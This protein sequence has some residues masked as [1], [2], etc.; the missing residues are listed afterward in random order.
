MKL[1]ITGA[2]GR[3]ASCFIDTYGAGYD[4]RLTDR[5]Y[6]SQEHAPVGEWRIGDLADP[7]FVWELM[8]GIEAVLHL[9]ANPNTNAPM[10][11][12]LNSNL[13]GTSNV[14]EA[15]QA[16]SVR[17]VVFA[18]SIQAVLGYQ[19]DTMVTAEMATRP[20]NL[21][22]A[23]KCFGESLCHV[24]STA[25]MSCIAVRIGAFLEPEWLERSRHQEVRRQYVSP[26]DLCQLLDLALRA[27][28][29][30]RFAI[31]HGVSDNAVNR[32]DL[33][34]TRELLGYSPEDGAPAPDLEAEARHAE[35][36]RR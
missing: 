29:D 33:S 18:S 6:P 20:R 35:S 4:L 11:S 21:Y 28:E 23:T 2:A 17:R 30:V 19:P 13:L 25:G 7:N 27:P 14:F 3:I 10:R 1:L 26:R 34:A 5:R 24:Y 9:G 22:A 16:R 36:H 8:D 15:A 32:L 31:V 12:L